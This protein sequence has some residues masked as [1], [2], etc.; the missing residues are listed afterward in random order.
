VF[1]PADAGGIAD[2]TTVATDTS[3]ELLVD[4]PVK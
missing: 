3:A 1:G 4:Q 2:A